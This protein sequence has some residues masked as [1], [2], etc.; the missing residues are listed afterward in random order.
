MVMDVPSSLLKNKV[1]KLKN[2]IIYDKF[3]GRKEEEKP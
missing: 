3:K 2:E 1:E